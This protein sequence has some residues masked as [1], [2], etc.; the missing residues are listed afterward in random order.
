[1]DKELNPPLETRNMKK[2]ALIL[3]AYLLM[4]AFSFGEAINKVCPISGKALG[5]ATSEVKVDFCCEKCKAKFDKEPVKFAK[6]V[7]SAE[8]GQCVVSGKDAK[9]ALTSTVTVGF[10]CEKCKAKFDKNPK[11]CFAKLAP[12]KEVEEKK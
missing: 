11:E 3:S 7:A 4:N 10:C 6:K 1:M 12:K 2:L 5:T 8:A 9:E